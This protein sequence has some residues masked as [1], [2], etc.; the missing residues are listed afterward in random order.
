MGFKLKNIY[1]CDFYYL[2][3]LQFIKWITASKRECKFILLQ[4]KHINPVIIREKDILSSVL[5]VKRLNFLKQIKFL[6]SFEIHF[7]RCLIALEVSEKFLCFSFLSRNAFK[8]KITNDMN[9]ITFS[10]NSLKGNLFY[11]IFLTKCQKCIDQYKDFL[12]F[13]WHFDD[14]FLNKYIPK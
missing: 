11:E 7:K 13:L 3:H 5:S 8:N 10:E 14:E 2:Q 6:E 12:D 4:L 9:Q 1:I